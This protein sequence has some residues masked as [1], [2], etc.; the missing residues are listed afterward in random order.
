M[1]K[2]LLN[3]NEA[4]SNG[5]NIKF[6]HQYCVIKARLASG[7]LI[8]I[9]CQQQGRLYPLRMMN[10]HITALST[11]AQ[12]T[13]QLQT[14]RWHYRM[15]HAPHQNLH[16]MQTKNMATGLQFR[17]TP[18]DICKGCIYGKTHHQH[19]HASSTRFNMPLQMI[20]RDL[21]GPMQNPSLSSASYFLTFIDDFTKYTVVS[22]VKQKLEVLEHFKTYCT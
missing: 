6:H 14:L 8:H 17:L 3:V 15:G 1:K 11:I 7:D 9:T 4:T 13:N 5:T 18:I 10:M 2:N 19:F 20:H 21:C 12:T 22:F 16:T